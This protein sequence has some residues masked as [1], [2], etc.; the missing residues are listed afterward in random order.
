M[1]PINPMTFRNYCVV[2]N[3]DKSLDSLAKHF[4]EEIKRIDIRPGGDP[5]VYVRT[6]D[7]ICR[8]SM[9]VFLLESIITPETGEENE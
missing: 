1:T 4:L 3:C 6:N 5:I 8:L 7:Q 2:N 9:L